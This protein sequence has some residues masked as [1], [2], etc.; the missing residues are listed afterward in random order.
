MV[1]LVAACLPTSQG[2][3]RLDWT[4]SYPVYTT[5]PVLVPVF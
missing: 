2:P 1:F 5:R 4:L 3:F